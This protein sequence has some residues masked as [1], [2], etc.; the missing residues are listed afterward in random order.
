MNPYLHGTVGRLGTVYF[1]KRDSNPDSLC[2]SHKLYIQF[3]DIMNLAL[4]NDLLQILILY[5]LLLYRF[6][7][8]LLRLERCT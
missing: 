7:P 1:S 3:Q 6:D 5:P 8:R 2:I 4:W